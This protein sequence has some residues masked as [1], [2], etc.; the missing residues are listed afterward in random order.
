MAVF[1]RRNETEKKGEKQPLF[2]SQAWRVY[3][4]TTRV[5]VTIKGL[6]MLQSRHARE[7]DWSI[8]ATNGGAWIN[9]Q[10]AHGVFAEHARP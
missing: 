9:G 6:Q 5:T 3:H 8:D 1:A 4:S 7:E 10:T 2:T